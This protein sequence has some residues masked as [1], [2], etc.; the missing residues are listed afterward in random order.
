MTQILDK[1]YSGLKPQIPKYNALCV[2]NIE[3]AKIAFKY[4]QCDFVFAMNE[5]VQIFARCV[6]LVECEQFWNNKP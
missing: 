1:D 4:G 6:S 5:N 3:S 2:F